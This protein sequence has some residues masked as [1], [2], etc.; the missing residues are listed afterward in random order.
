MTGRLVALPILSGIE[1]K[2]SVMFGFRIK[3]LIRTFINREQ[4]RQ[5]ELADIF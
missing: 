1:L 3:G 2:D 4:H 5:K